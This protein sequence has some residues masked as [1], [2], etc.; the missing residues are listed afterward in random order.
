MQQTMATYQLK[1]YVV[2]IVDNAL[3]LTPPDD[4]GNIY[5]LAH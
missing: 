4:W 5:I 2:G 3:D 1:P